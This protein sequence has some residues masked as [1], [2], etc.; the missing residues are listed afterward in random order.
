VTT[1]DLLQLV[2]HASFTPSGRQIR[3]RNEFYKAQAGTPLPD[4]ELATALK[5]GAPA[6]I[7]KWWTIPGFADWFTSPTWEKEESHRL[8]IAAM[9]RVGEVLRDEQDSG[10]VL[11]AAKE[12]REIYV[13]LNAPDKEDKYMDDEIGKMD[14]QQLEEYIR[15]AQGG[16]Q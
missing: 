16:K 5:F 10:R 7:S 4:Q 11:A 15:R 13:K 9:H 12:A 6:V 2:A 3:A 1:P 8:L 14:K